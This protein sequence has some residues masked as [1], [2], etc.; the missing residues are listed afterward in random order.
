MHQQHN[1]RYARGSTQLEGA[2]HRTFLISLL[3]RG[4][5][6]GSKT[7]GSSTKG[8]RNGSGI[9]EE[10]NSLKELDRLS[11]YSFFNDSERHNNPQKQDKQ[12]MG[13]G[14]P[15]QKGGGG[16]AQAGLLQQE[17]FGSGSA[18]NSGGGGFVSGMGGYP[19]KAINGSGGGGNRSGAEYG[20]G[21]AGIGYGSGVGGNGS[22]YGS[23]IARHGEHVHSQRDVEEHVYFRQSGA[24]YAGDHARGARGYAGEEASRG[25][26]FHG[27]DSR[28]GRGHNWEEASSSPKSVRSSGHFNKPI[29]P[30]SADSDKHLERAIEQV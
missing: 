15:P 9:A 3:C 11:K 12:H 22:G 14:L 10:K 1:R 30:N 20:S 29:R 26:G 27:E 28:A 21:V 18:Y 13:G 19:H 6:W 24:G 23:N 5:S 4:S 25:R 8:G 2:S 16:G 17:G 7:L